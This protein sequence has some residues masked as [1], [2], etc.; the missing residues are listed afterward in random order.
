MQGRVEEKEREGLRKELFAVLKQLS[1]TLSIV[2]LALVSSSNTDR[3]A[4]MWFGSWQAAKAHRLPAVYQFLL[5]LVTFLTAVPFH[6]MTTLSVLSS[7]N[8]KGVQSVGQISRHRRDSSP[9]WASATSQSVQSNYNLQWQLELQR[10]WAAKKRKEK[11]AKKR[12]EKAAKRVLTKSRSMRWW[13]RK[14]PTRR[15]HSPLPSIVTAQAD[16]GRSSSTRI[17][18]VICEKMKLIRVTQWWCGHSPHLSSQALAIWLALKLF[19]HSPHWGCSPERVVLV[20]HCPQLWS[21]DTAG[22][23]GGWRRR[24]FALRHRVMSALIRHKWSHRA[25]EVEWEIQG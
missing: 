25:V 7:K 3:I 15:M 5:F 4:R 10:R 21:A 17:P 1:S 9:L 24:C 20:D 14:S 2:T 12:K 23:G 18:P 22:R 11:A 13:T 6:L 19:L 8:N 16:V